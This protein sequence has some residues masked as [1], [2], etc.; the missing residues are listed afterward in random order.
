MNKYLEQKRKNFFLAETHK[1]N[2][3]KVLASFPYWVAM[4]PASIC[5]LR[6][7]FCPTGQKRGTRPEKLLELSLFKKIMDSLGPYLIHMDLVNWGEPLMNPDVF[8]MIEYAKTYGIHIKIDTNATLLNE[9]AAEKIVKSGLDKII[10][11]IDGASEETYPIYRK[12]G[13]FKEV[14]E[15]AK[16]LVAAK[17]AAG[18]STPII[19]WQFL[20]FRHNQH[21]MDLARTLAAEAGV[22]EIN[23]T[24]PYAGDPAWLSDIE[25][26]GGQ[27]Y[28]VDE[29]SVSFKRQSPDM[30]CNWLWDGIAVNADG[31]VSACCSVEDAEDDFTREFPENFEEFWNSPQLLEAREHVIKTLPPDPES[32]NVCVK[33]DHWGWSN[34][35]DPGFILQNMLRKENEGK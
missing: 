11:S 34:H 4:D 17:K 2:R 31:S 1:K 6:C 14:Y 10:L 29:E 7:P 13:S 8:S 9:K 26:F 32:S 20:V 5:N 21:E 19:E 16:N 15:N 18:S 33:C 24:P 12:G 27:H 25:P 30:L 3:D 35:M 28:D 22:D 23:F